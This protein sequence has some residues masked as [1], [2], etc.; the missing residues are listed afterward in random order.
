MLELF[1]TGLFSH[2]HMEWCWLGLG[3]GHVIYLSFNMGSSLQ[4]VLTLFLDSQGSSSLSLSLFL[5]PP[6]GLEACTPG[7][8]KAREKRMKQARKE[9][10][11]EGRRMFGSFLIK[12]DEVSYPN[13][14]IAQICFSSRVLDWVIGFCKDRLTNTLQHCVCIHDNMLPT[15][16]ALSF[17]F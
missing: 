15:C 14:R 10:R 16:T 3:L 13:F 7:E 2:I 5:F 1:H 4:Y 9:G 11:K 12:L 6:L 8:M 17:C